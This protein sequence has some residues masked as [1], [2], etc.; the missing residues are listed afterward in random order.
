M[1]GILAVF[2]VGATLMVLLVAAIVQLI[3][4][5]A[6]LLILTAAAYAVFAAARARRCRRAPGPDHLEV[7]WAT[8][9]HAAYAPTVPPPVRPHQQR[10]YLVMHQDSGFTAARPYGYL[11][12]QPHPLPAEHRT[13]GHHI[14]RLPS[15]AGFH[16]RAGASGPTRR[17]SRP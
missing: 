15:T 1:K 2:G 7:L 16:R 11:T 4:R 9:P 14:R 13:G 8:G 12:L 5:L 10:T 6:P 17:C 3:M